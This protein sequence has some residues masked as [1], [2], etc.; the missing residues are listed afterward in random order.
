MNEVKRGGEKESYSLDVLLNE[1]SKHLVLL[2]HGI[3]TRALWMDI[4][5]PALERAGFSVAPISY[6]E[7]GV[8]RFLSFPF[9]RR[10]AIGRVLGG[11]DTATRVYRDR[12]GLYPDRVSIISHSFGTWL[13]L[14][15]LSL[16][17]NLK[18]SRL[19]VCG[20]VLREDFNF[21]PVL[22]Q[23]QPPMLNEIGTKDYLP[24]I[25]ESVGWGY[26]HAGHKPTIS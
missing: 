22:H 21:D 8:V 6:G 1:N 7:F 25:A 20:S 4:V 9:L 10:A 17:P 18:F 16:K 24:A 26:G 5:Q 23:F 12:T 3:N 11:I 14:T 15:I 19:V 13:I 2:V